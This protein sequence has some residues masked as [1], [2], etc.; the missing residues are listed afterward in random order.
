MQVRYQRP[1]DDGTL[2]LVDTAMILRI[3]QNSAGA[4]TYSEFSDLQ[5]NAAGGV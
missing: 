4:Y 1:A 5:Y 3:T 2:S